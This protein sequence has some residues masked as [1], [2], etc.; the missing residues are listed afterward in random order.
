MLGTIKCTLPISSFQVTS[1]YS[2]C[3]KG[4][5]IRLAEQ[6][7]WVSSKKKKRRGGTS[8]IT[9]KMVPVAQLQFG[10]SI[11]ANNINKL[12]KAMGLLSGAQLTQVQAELRVISALSSMTQNL[13]MTMVLN[14]TE[15]GKALW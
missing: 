15:A 4:A 6:R 10:I 9:Y 12:E 5:A 2:N 14:I 8:L 13:L 1:I 11:K 3:S 7:A